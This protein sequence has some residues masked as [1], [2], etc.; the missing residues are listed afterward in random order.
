MNGP[1]TC[2]Y[3]NA[4]IN[5]LNHKH[6]LYMYCIDDENVN[7][8]KSTIENKREQIRILEEEIKSIQDSC[9]HTETFEESRQ[10][11]IGSSSNFKICKN[12]DK[13]ILNL[14][15][16]LDYTITTTND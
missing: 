7:D 16:I 1:D 14:D 4:P 2:P 13:T 9:T 6:H 3:C 8:M 10:W 5:Y 15:I 11:R 12:C